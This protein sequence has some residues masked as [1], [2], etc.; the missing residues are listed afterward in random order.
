MSTPTIYGDIVPGGTVT[1]HDNHGVYVGT[2]G[3]DGVVRYN[4]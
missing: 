1:V 2:V 4:K 3:Y